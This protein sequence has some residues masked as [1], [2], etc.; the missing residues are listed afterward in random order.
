M[1]K[2]N[3]AMCFTG[4]FLLVVAFITEPQRAA[5]KAY[6][7]KSAFEQCIDIHAKSNDTVRADA[8]LGNATP[9]DHLR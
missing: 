4:V 5:N 2:L 7:A 3:K 1:N 8:F 6:T 9:C